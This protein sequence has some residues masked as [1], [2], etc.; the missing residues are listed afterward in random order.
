MIT[1]IWIITFFAAMMAL[2]Y[3][4]A[5]LPVWSVALFVL[6]VF[7]VGLG[8]TRATTLWVLGIAYLVVFGIL[9][10]HFLRRRLISNPI[11]KRY[12]IL[13]P[14]MSET[15]TAA[16]ESGTVGW[17]GDLFSGMPNWETLRDMPLSE[18]TE[19]ES[20]FIQGP[21]EEICRSIDNWDIARTMEIPDTIWSFFKSAGF[22]GMIIPK[23]YGGK[24]FSALA[25]AQV[26][27]K[28]AS[29]NVAVATVASVPNSLGPGELLLRYGTEEQK[30]H[31]LPRLASGEEIPC[32][33]LTSPV[34]GSDAGSI[35][36]TGIVCRHVFEGR[37][38]LCLRLNWDKRYITLSPVATLIGLAFKCY[39]P[40]HLLGEQENLGIT[41]ALVPSR[42]P[43]V[44]TGRR[45]F[46]L[47]S[48]FPNGPTQGKDVLIPLDWVIGGPAMIGQG[49]RMLME[50]LAAGRSISL[51]SMVGANAK[52]AVLASGAYARIRRQFNAPIAEFE[53]IQEVLARM[54][55]RTYSVEALR[56]L[57]L[58]YLNKGETPAVASAISKYHATE[59]S[60]MVIN[61]AMDIQGGKGICM[62][63]SNYLAQCYIE[64]PIGITVEG[65]NILTR[66]LMIY[67]QG[68]IRCH[69]YLLAEM[70]AASKPEDKHSL[71]AFDRALF[72]HMGFLGSNKA[73]SFCLGLSNGRGTWGSG[74]SLKRYYQ[75]FT[76]FSA[77]L[78]L[79]SD[80][81]TLL[82]GAQLK[83]REMLSAR[84]G[85]VLSLLYIGSSVLKYHE[86]RNI[87]EELPLARWACKDLLYRIQ[88]QIDGLIANLPSIFVRFWLRVLIFPRGKNLQPPS[89]ALSREVAQLLTQPG[90]VRERFSEN[91]YYTPHSNNPVAEME[92]VLAKV[93]AVEPIEIKIAKA[94]RKN[95]ISGYSLKEVAASAV[96]A[97]IITKAEADDLLEADKARMTVINVDDFLRDEI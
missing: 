85:D 13:M 86:H 53:G 76:R 77:A 87:K 88:T 44:V 46:P 56:A 79:L 91:I 96:S 37:E 51:P 82:I 74:T 75:L 78:A 95:L 49:W 66:S 40:Q 69:P 59:L 62:G 58:T 63:P 64:G 3:H 61:D 22:F 28:L 25:H 17:E 1:L 27:L 7:L 32:F 97:N 11:F 9:N 84:L 80:A 68:A 14:R 39:D 73:R 35:A 48:A 31:Y 52:R 65:A 33:A 43:G 36:D 67:G 70:K 15:E 81:T 18:L 89:D 54:A 92:A 57:T 24:E 5:S 50:C 34:A 45:H 29:A 42:M 10:I 8:Q 6:L 26:I 72:A 55:G 94:Y 21:V 4:R 41:C 38:Q 83:R 2:A 19:E 71:M 47:H 23:K 60:R 20:D 90:P 12:Q 30:N 93:I 16:L